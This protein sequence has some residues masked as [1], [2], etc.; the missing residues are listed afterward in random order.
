M[1]VVQGSSIINQPPIKSA[2]Q[3]YLDYMAGLM[4]WDDVIMELGMV[5]TRKQSL[6]NLNLSGETKVISDINDKMADVHDLMSLF[7]TKLSDLSKLYPNSTNPAD[8][9]TVNTATPAVP[10]AAFDA[11]LTGY[12]IAYTDAPSPPTDTNMT[13][14]Q[15]T[16]GNSNLQLKVDD[17]SS[18]S[19]QQQGVL[20][21]DI[22]R[23]DSLSE[24]VSALFQRAQE[25]QQAASGRR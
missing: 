21:R 11:R 13:R 9:T 25:M 15:M 16:T 7:N 17:L 8:S 20:Q 10:R 14:T 23:L 5:L 19:T 24:L 18:Q 12:G 1:T 22:G 3:R 4:T 6:M 2:D